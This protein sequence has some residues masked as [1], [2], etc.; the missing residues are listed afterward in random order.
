M[1]ELLSVVALVVAVAAFYRSGLK[2]PVK[3]KKADRKPPMPRT[4]ADETE[5]AV[6]K[7]EHQNFMRY[8]GEPQKPINRNTILAESGE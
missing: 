4:A 5:R 1:G 2:P 3:A 7:R 6:C 8:D